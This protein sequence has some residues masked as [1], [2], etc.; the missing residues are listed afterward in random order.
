[1]ASSLEGNKIAAAILTA[2]I[3]AVGSSVLTDLLYKPHVPKERSYVVAAGGGGEPAATAAAVPA[4]AEPIAVRLAAADVEAGKAAAKKCVSCHTLEKGGRNGVGPNLWGVVAAPKGHVEGFAYS[5]ALLGTG[6]T[7]TYESLDAFIAN[8][9]AYAPG[10]KMSFA[11]ITKPEERANLI[12][13]LRTLADE[14]APLPG[15]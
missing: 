3:I 13:Y 15:S 7:W 4:P 2:G 1:M 14:P 10:T 6:G 11:G 12:A 8:P 5:Q 9:K